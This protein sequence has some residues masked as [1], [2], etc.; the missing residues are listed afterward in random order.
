MYCLYKGYCTN[1]YLFESDPDI[2]G[3]FSAN[4]RFSDTITRCLRGTIGFY[5]LLCTDKPF[6]LKYQHFVFAEHIDGLATNYFMRYTY[7]CI[8]IENTNN[9]IYSYVC[10]YN[11]LNICIYIN[12][13]V[14]ETKNREVENQ[15]MVKNKVTARRDPLPAVCYMRFSEFLY[16]IVFF[17][18]YFGFSISFFFYF[19][20]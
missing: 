3:K 13:W 5:F 8:H 15:I 11:L 20:F 12:I 19:R 10:I 1:C 7:V 6:V 16:Q 4:I 18:F 9:H 17:L 2:C 14:K